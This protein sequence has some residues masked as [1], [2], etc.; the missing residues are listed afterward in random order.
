MV[1]DT[2]PEAQRVYILL[3]RLVPPWKKLHMLGE[4]NLAAREL[5][6]L[7]L[8]SRYPNLSDHELR[9]KLAELLLGK[10]VAHRVYGN[11]IESC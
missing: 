6:M 3:L 1:S 2:R 9:Y 7:G 5:A 8:R 10:E 11:L 4:L